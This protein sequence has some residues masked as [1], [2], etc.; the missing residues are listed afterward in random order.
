MKYDR[1][2]KVR[3]T[4]DACHHGGV[5]GVIVGRADYAADQAAPETH[6]LPERP[7]EDA[8]VVR[9]RPAGAMHD[10]TRWFYAHEIE[11]VDVTP[12]PAAPMR[13]AQ[14]IGAHVLIVDKAGSHTGQAGIVTGR[15]EGEKPEEDAYLIRYDAPLST[16]EQ[17]RNPLA[18]SK[19]HTRW[20]FPAHLSFAAE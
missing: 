13:H 11:P 19:T 7:G 8:Y 20:C 10:H 16:G 3:M 18:T 2:L 4:A 12:P 5:E 15:F 9:F 17:M 1:G 6:E 14:A